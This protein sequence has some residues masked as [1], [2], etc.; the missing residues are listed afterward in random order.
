MK[1]KS[2][3]QG[4]S[5]RKTRSGSPSHSV[6]SY[7][8]HRQTEIKDFSNTRHSDLTPK[9]SG[10]ESN[11]RRNA[12]FERSR[13]D[14][15]FEEVENKYSTERSPP[16]S[17]QLNEN[18]IMQLLPTKEESDTDESSTNQEDNVRLD[19]L[20]HE[21]KYLRQ[22]NN[23]LRIDVQNMEERVEQL[24]RVLEEC[25][26]T[27]ADAVIEEEQYFNEMGKFMKV[28]NENVGMSETMKVMAKLVQRQERSLKRHRQ[29]STKHQKEMKKFRQ[30]I[31]QL[32]RDLY[33]NQQKLFDVQTKDLSHK[34]RV[35]SL[36][37]QIAYMENQLQSYQRS[38]FEDQLGQKSLEHDLNIS[39]Q[40]LE[41]LRLP[42][43]PEAP[44]RLDSS[45]NSSC[46]EQ[47]TQTTVEAEPDF[48]ARRNTPQTKEELQA[49]K[50]I[51]ELE[52][53]YL[54]SQKKNMDNMKMQKE[55]CSDIS[56]VSISSEFYST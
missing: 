48:E 35:E 31:G 44:P 6:D 28:R 36:R 23:V 12:N 47:S 33:A 29:Q 51:L 14:E 34:K 43:S 42:S 7:D 22:E 18:G 25:K 20:S 15:E 5:L 39:K 26:K 11:Y 8:R 24:Q 41:A 40:L 37:R 46:S 30:I 1:L 38:H 4:C 27:K 13:P 9:R 53:E 16:M 45:V 10:Y 32:E 56:D 21:N 49:Q 52:R 55:I 2:V 17:A 19:E 54:L 50:Y 3:V